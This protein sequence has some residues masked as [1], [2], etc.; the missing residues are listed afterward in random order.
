MEITGVTP[1][2]RTAVINFVCLDKCSLL[3]MLFILV[4]IVYLFAIC[5]GFVV[6]IWMVLNARFSLEFFKL[7]FHWFVE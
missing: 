6:I 2:L 3:Y 7:K 4:T 5:G 1:D